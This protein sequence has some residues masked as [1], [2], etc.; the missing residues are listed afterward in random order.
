M[1]FGVG[2]FWGCFAAILLAF[3]QAKA[4]PSP[5]FDFN[6]D[7]RSFANWTVFSYENGRIVSHK[8][9]YGHHYSRRCFVMTRAVAQF[10]KFARFEPTA[11]K[12]DDNEL[13]KRIRAITRKAPWHDALPPEKRI[14]I[15]GYRNLRE[16]STGQTQL[17]QR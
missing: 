13:R 3:S 14:V 2:R 8:N 6:R 11:P 7:T 4:A 1:R 17:M 9:Q 16:L 15:P 10:Y 12:A 5:G